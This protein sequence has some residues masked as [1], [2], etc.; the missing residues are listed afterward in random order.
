[1]YAIIDQ[2]ARLRARHVLTK[3]RHP[4]VGLRARVVAT[5]GAD[6]EE[7]LLLGLL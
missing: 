3:V 5:H 1:M 6:V 2:N 4:A 7:G